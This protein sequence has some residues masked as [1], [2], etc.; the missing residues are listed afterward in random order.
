MTDDLKES[1]IPT[2]RAAANQ[3]QPRLIN[4]DPSYHRR[5]LAAS[6]LPKGA[7]LAMT[8]S[9]REGSGYFSGMPYG[10]TPYSGGG[11]GGGS[12]LYHMQRPYLPQVESPDRVQYPKSREE[13]NEDWR[14][15]HRVDP[16]FGCAIDMYAEML[17]SD[18]DIVVGDEKSHEIRDTLEYMCQVTNLMDRLRYIVRDYLVFGEAIPHCFFDDD[19]G[20]WTYIGMHDP[21]YV[22]VIDAPIVN[23]DPI[24]NFVPDESIR[25]LL[26]DGSPESREFRSRLPA[27]FVAK[28]MARQKIRLSPLNATFIPR[29][30]H[31][32]EV[33]GTSLASRMWRIFMVEDAV[34]NSTI[35]TYRRH[36]APVK[37]I[38][39]GDPQ[40]GW[41]PAPGAEVKLL[42][43]LNRAEADPQAWIIYHYGINFEA[44]GTTDRAIS[45]HQQHDVIEKVKLLA[46]GLS[47]SFMTGEVT[48]ACS[49]SRTPVRKGDSS[50]VGVEEIRKGDAVMDRFGKSR[51]VVDVLEYPAP[52]EMVK[53]TL[54]GD[55]E[56]TLT[57]YHELP[58]FA[59]PHKCLCGCG[60]DLGD[61]KGTSQG[62]RQ[63][64][65]FSPQHHKNTLRAGRDREWIDYKHGDAVIASFPSE[66]YPYQRLRADEVRMGDWLMI[67]R[68][69][70]VSATPSS[71]ENLAK[72]RLLGYYAAEGSTE[73]T[74]SDS[75]NKTTRF[76]FGRVDCA[77]EEFYVADV[78]ELLESF[79]HLCTI[80]RSYKQPDSEVP[81]FTVYV[82]TTATPLSTYLEENGGKGSGTKR[83]S[84]EVMGWN[85]E[86]KKEL[87]KGM[88]R[89]DGYLFK[90]GNR[91]DVV[92]TTTSTQL[93]R[94]LEVILAQLGYSC[95]VHTSP[96]RR[97][98]KGYVHQE[99]HY[100]TCSG[101]Q[102]RPLAELVWSEVS[103]VWDEVDWTGFEKDNHQGERH[104][105]FVDDE[106]IY[107]P[108]KSVETVQVDKKLNPYVYSLTVQETSSYTLNNVASFNS[109]KSG[110]QVFLRRLLSLR[111]FLENFWLYPKFFR[112]ISEINEWFTAKP[113]EVHHRYRIKRTA[114]EIEEENMI[115][116]PTLKWRN[117]LDP[118]VDQDLLQAYAMLA[119]FG[120]QISDSTVAGAVG[121]DATEE[122]EKSM[123]EFKSKREKIEQTLGKDLAREFLQQTQ[124]AGA[125]G[126][127]PP[128]GP[129]AGA[130][131]PGAAGKPSGGMDDVSKPPGSAPGGGEALDEGIERPAGGGL[132]TGVG[133]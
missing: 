44:W 104:E 20:I 58:V 24:L 12:S 22:E 131:P 106:Y 13:A 122:L 40:T 132:P 31:L 50:Y 93:M 94:Q 19:L 29:K 76:S 28:I 42:E 47:K 117:K 53:I 61:E 107:L 74:V 2:R 79:G 1:F 69:F 64:R 102:A 128:G 99:C 30:L 54:Y 88:Y 7:T 127:K 23:M 11:G 21:D 65:S 59:R 92:Y 97:D 100:I 46:L 86:L 98:E 14:L 121:L 8:P 60:E 80:Q 125:G 77:K 63:W 95:Y 49:L 52:D 17:V 71:E 118:G 68:G 129:G 101:K 51:K 91:L 34:Y 103:A 109:A 6:V 70:E 87:L 108:V 112:P 133:D 123:K 114:Q 55:R 90:N 57:D 85:L 83:L 115:L 113:S 18:F 96:E 116:M 15:F 32:H 82:P 48:Y 25:R 89:G 62:R 81:S 39:L 45:I 16:I 36:A 111:Q 5:E 4:A 56:L 73:F 110:L 26:S 35:A 120:I 10:V 75:G 78:A 33:R 124:Q 66:H 72:A 43:M 37:V 130:K 119:K 27:E 84:S 38:K 67:P 126:A 105:V 41:I 9:R 3:F